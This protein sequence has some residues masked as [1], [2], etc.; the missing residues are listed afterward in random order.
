MAGFGTGDMKK[1]KVE[2][3]L[4]G[5]LA[6]LVVIFAVVKCIAEG[7]R[8]AHIM[9]AAIT[10]CGV[11]VS[12]L[13]LFS[14]IRS[15]WTRHR[16]LATFESTLSHELQLWV[17]RNH[18]MICVDN[19][20][21]G[22]RDDDGGNYSLLKQFDTILRR[23]DD[24]NNAQRVPFLTLPSDYTN[25]SKIIF[26]LNPEIFQRRADALKEDVEI[27]I[28]KLTKD[29]ANCISAEFPNLAKAHGVPEG[30]VDKVTVFLIRDL[31]TSEDARELINMLN[32]VTILFLAT[33]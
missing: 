30:R 10:I 14:A 19:P 32:Y 7:G 4:G 8:L 25:G 16:P 17:R 33:A 11:V 2:G 31:D 5:C 23:H 22:P 12:V 13:V 29:F 21:D 15:Y 20:F 26:H 3:W 18:P 6:V 9:T 27:T 28:T 24:F 1:A